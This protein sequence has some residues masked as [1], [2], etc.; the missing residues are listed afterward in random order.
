MPYAQRWTGRVTLSRPCVCDLA[1]ACGIALAYFLSARIALSLIVQ[2][3][4]IAAIWP[5]SGLLL[6][7]LVLRSRRSWPLTLLAVGAAIT[8]ANLI[9]GKTVA[10]SL[11]FALAN[12]AESV[13]AAWLLI[14]YLGTPVTCTSFREV[15]GLVGLAAFASNAL[16]ALLGAVVA[17]LGLGAPFWETWRLWCIADGVGMLLV[18]PVILTWAAED[19]GELKSF[20][21]RRGVEA[22]CLVAALAVLTQ[23]VFGA[24]SGHGRLFLTLPYPIFP[25]LLWAAVRF[26]PRG[27]T[28][29][30]LELAGLVVW[31]TVRG[32][33]PFAA[34]GG[35][36]NMQILEV[37]AFLGV[38]GL[39]SSLTAAAMSERQQSIEALQRSEAL[40]RAIIDNTTAVIFVKAA[41]GR[42]LFINRQTEKVFNITNEQVQGKT[43]HVFMPTEVAD[44]FQRGDMQVLQTGQPLQSEVQ[45]P[46]PDGIHT[47]ITLRVPLCHASGRPY[48]VVGISTDITERQRAEAKFRQLLEVAPDA[49]VIVNSAGE[50]VLSNAQTERLFGYTQAELSGQPVELLMPERFRGSHLQSRL[51]YF[52]QP[53]ARPMGAGLDLYG[54][55]RDGR[56]FPVEI[57]LSPLATE[58]GTLVNAAIRDVTER[59]SLEAALRRHEK[60]LRE[61]IDNTPAIIYIKSADGRYLLV[62]RQFETLYKTTN[63][64]LIGKTAYDVLPKDLADRLHALDMQVLQSCSAVQTEEYA[65]R[66]DGR[67]TYLVLKFPLL[68]AGGVSYAICGISTDITERKAMEEALQHTAADLARSNADLEQFAY[69][70]S[71]DLQEPLRGVVGCL[72]L[73]QQRYSGQLDARGEDYIRRAVEGA[74]RMRMLIQ[75]LLAYSRVTSRGAAFT[76][77]DCSDVL[78]RALANLKVAI[79]ESGAVVTSTSLPTVP[80]DTT[81]LQ[82]VFQ[83]LVGNAIKFRAAAP[84]AIHI[85]AERYE[86]EWRFAVRDNGIGIEPQYAKRIFVLFQ[87]LHT[88]EE[89]PGTGIGLALCQK[90]VER[91]GGSIWVESALGQGATF[92]FTLPSRS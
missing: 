74:N 59:K 22:L 3:E 25:C 91:H 23:L 5:P 1:W 28:L 38:A 85:S 84:P 56:E 26:G 6:A 8:T 45:A 11:G 41:D 55:T 34:L 13:L 60:L 61:L 14:R 24:H 77:T 53:A 42:Y 9:T 75:D 40:Q 89:Y 30:A 83:N 17:T 7:V 70:A 81:Q 62:N 37:Q 88:R 80:G 46:L 78:E 2:P 48:A 76:P 73:L 51:H 68:D 92:F 87:R 18:A 52:A 43:A 63:A 50:I 32:R 10:V 79:D 21:L 54:R 66:A 67:H 82:R 57:S 58:E 36:V 33:G 16:T 71:H 44:E 69:V 47:Y 64:Q 29:V 35:A 90:I 31:N 27:A 15:L 49:M 39:I 4:G 12:G 72:Q 20:T 65:Q 19:V 86:D